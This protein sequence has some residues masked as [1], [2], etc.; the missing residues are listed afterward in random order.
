MDMLAIG[1]STACA[2]HCILLPMLVVALPAL[3]GSALMDEKFHLILLLGIVPTSVI[4]LF[5]GCRKHRHWHL[6]GWG[7]AG[8]LTLILAALFGHHLLGELGEKVLTLGG[9]LLIAI[10]HIKNFR[11]CKAGRCHA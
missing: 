9:S 6:F 8:L 2:V 1:I 11:Y 5:M 10:G 3:A 7:V 4:A